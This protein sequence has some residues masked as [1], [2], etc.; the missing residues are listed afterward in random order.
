MDDWEKYVAAQAR[1]TLNHL[2]RSYGA[3]LARCRGSRGVRGDSDESLRR[4]GAGDAAHPI[5]Q[6]EKLRSVRRR[7]QTT[8]PALLPPPGRGLALRAGRGHERRIPSHS[9]TGSPLYGNRR[10]RE[11]VPGGPVGFKIGQAGPAF[12]FPTVDNS[13]LSFDSC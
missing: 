13:P 9:A 6:P 11:L 7:R 3:D 1:M 2:D 5:R 12:S 10:R 4:N 8:Q